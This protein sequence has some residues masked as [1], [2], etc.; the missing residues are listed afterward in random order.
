MKETQ[1]VFIGCLPAETDPTEIEQYFSKFCLM[2]KM[3]IKY[4]SNN[5]CAGYGHFMAHFKSPEESRTLYS[6]RHFYHGR[7]LECRPYLTGQ[8]LYDY[9]TEF[10]KRRVYVGN[11]P[12]FYDDFQL[13]KLFM[14][15]GEIQ[16]AYIANNPDKGGKT[17][18][19]VI[20]KEEGL[21]ASVLGSSISTE[22][23]QLLIQKVTRN[24]GKGTENS[25]DGENE[26]NVKKNSKLKNEKIQRNGKVKSKGKFSTTEDII[27]E[28]EFNKGDYFN[29]KLQKNAI[30]CENGRPKNLKFKHMKRN[31]KGSSIEDNMI[32][33][34]EK[35]VSSR[36]F[37]SHWEL[38]ARI[39]H[40]PNQRLIDEV[41]SQ[42]PYFNRFY[43]ANDFGYKPFHPKRHQTRQTDS[44]RHQKLPYVE[45]INYNENYYQD[46]IKKQSIHSIYECDVMRTK[47]VIE[48]CA[49]KRQALNLS[50]NKKFTKIDCVL[51]L[52][53]E[54]RVNQKNLANLNFNFKMKHY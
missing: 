38:E 7:S 45:P 27:K 37:R 26:K 10:N 23:Y 31:F 54:I 43:S 9:Q 25:G 1:K 14:Q 44:K 29:K 2:S 13:L 42:N 53:H 35:R 24:K 19:F 30:Y 48:T 52:N 15:F 18:G 50:Y 20:F 47:K 28:P 12:P 51:E 3:K 8:S 40:R 21:L 33:F 49:S 34:D 46:L 16:R 32:W 22:G 5:V 4:R 17:F 6:S 41:D 11:L 39:D 36:K